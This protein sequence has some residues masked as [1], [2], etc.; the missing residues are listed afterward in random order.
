MSITRRSLLA[1]ILA[2]RIALIFIAPTKL[3]P[4]W[5]PKQFKIDSLFLALLDKDGNEVSGDG[6]ARVPY[7]K[8]RIAFPIPT[9]SWG[10]VSSVMIPRLGVA[11]LNN[12]AHIL[13]GDDVSGTFNLE[14]FR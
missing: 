6:Y 14:D 13:G 5:V 8:G 3:M 11:R 9:S 4:L 1:G 2:S 7:S 12:P 10:L